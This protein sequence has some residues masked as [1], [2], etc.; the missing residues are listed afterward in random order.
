MPSDLNGKKNKDMPLVLQYL[1][2]CNLLLT[3]MIIISFR[4]QRV[5]D[6]LLCH[7]QN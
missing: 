6:A 7:L 2:T 3:H 5:D 1:D 4:F